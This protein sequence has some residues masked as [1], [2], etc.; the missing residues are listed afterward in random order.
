MELFEVDVFETGPFTGNPLAVIVEDG[1]LT[2]DEMQRIAAWTNFSET[3]FLTSASTAE[4]D[5]GVRIF[6]RHKELPFA[7]HPTLGTARAW[8]AAGNAPRTPG[9][10]IQQCGAGMVPV[11]V[12]GDSLAFATPPRIQTGPL[13]ESLVQRIATSLGLGR[14]DIVA[15]EW[16]TNGPV[17]HLVQVRDADTVRNCRIGA[18]PEYLRIGMVGLEPAGAPTAYEVRAILHDGEDP[19][20]GSLNGAAAQWLRAR[21]LVPSSYR[22]AQ[23]CRV[24]R[25]GRID[26][27]DDGN[28]IWIGGRATVRVRGVLLT[29]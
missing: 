1:S 3:T 19:V 27:L 29:A 26:V 21:G 8:L 12:E 18:V 20:T 17:W 25:N 28:D 24:G 14:E 5:Y 4:A 2:S 6:T 13:P 10:L 7:G 22:V 15:H 9:L 23:G 16:G 11:R